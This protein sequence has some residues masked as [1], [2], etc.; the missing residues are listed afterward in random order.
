ML[1]EVTSFYHNLKKKDNKQLDLQ[2][3]ITNATTTNV[4]H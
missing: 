2:M 1:N 3:A 4:F